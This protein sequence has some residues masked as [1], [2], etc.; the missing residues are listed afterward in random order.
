[1]SAG[2]LD[3]A[4]A[5][6]SRLAP[7]QNVQRSQIPCGSEP[8]RES[9]HP[10]RQALGALLLSLL[11]SNLLAAEPQ[12]RVQ[13]QL[14]P[15]TDIMVGSL[16]RL[17]VDV[18]TDSWFTSA[19]TLPDLALPGALVMPPNGE[20][21]HIT[22]TLDG[23]PF[24]GM[25][26]TYLITPNQAQAF[27]IPAL[28]VRATPAQ[29]SQVLSAQSPPLH[30]SAQLPPGFKAGEPVLVAQ[31]LRLTQT[32][33]PSATSLNV[34]DTLTRQLTLQADGALAMGL[35]APPLVDVDGLRRYLNTPQVS[36]LDDGRGNHDGGQ[37]IDSASYRVN[38]PGQHTLPAIDVQWWDAS[39]Q[40]ARVA[41][42]P[43]VTFEA[44]ANPGYQPVFS[45]DQDLQRLGQKSRVHLS[46]HWLLLV[47]SL[48]VLGGLAYLLK[49][50]CVRAWHALQ[51]RRRARRDAW[52]ESADYAWKQIP[53]QLQGQPPQLG[54]LYLWAR[55]SRLGLG[56]GALG[57]EARALLRRCYGPVPE[58]AQAFVRI[59]ESLSTLHHQAE[60]E[61]RTGA[62]TL[63]PLNP[64]H[65][66]DLP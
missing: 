12:L 25:R 37:R 53:A 47:A 46:Q 58:K 31:A 56:I 51:N 13:A 42:V 15:A 62:A 66:K 9:T 55:R 54:A 57:G 48:L 4:M 60:R 52:M 29:A 41:S 36:N 38:T 63:R 34:G 45:I 10:V 49:P 21:Q 2:L 17:Q 22:Q 61:H 14:Q 3:R 44:V 64:R 11:A 8:A 19:A 35:P 24:F 28:T 40:Q 43:A 1:M 6:A 50:G 30:F 26:Y 7:T 27:D 33:T 20:A 59:R 23:T 5:F 39:T 65:E 32:I 18:L 16:V